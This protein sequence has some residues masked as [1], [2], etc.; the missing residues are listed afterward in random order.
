M[1]GIAKLT[2]CELLL[3]F[4][5]LPIFLGSTSPEAG[6]V[7]ELVARREALEVVK[8]LVE[9]VELGV[10][11]ALVDVELDVEEAL[12]EVDLDVVEALVVVEL[13]V[14][15]A[16]VEA[17]LVEAELIVVAALA[18]AELEVVE[19]LVEVNFELLDGVLGRVDAATS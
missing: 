5:R 17:E 12:V 15:A 3:A 1:A 9:V 18:E 10:V 6:T 19:A 8:A 14:V 7:D 16:L 11:E 2:S 4:L 13:D